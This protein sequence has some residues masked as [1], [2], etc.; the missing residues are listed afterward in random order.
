[1]AKD[2]FTVKLEDADPI[3]KDNKKGAPRANELRLEDIDPIFKDTL[4][5]PSSISSAPPTPSEL[6]NLQNLP[7]SYQMARRAIFGEQPIPPGVGEFGGGTLGAVAGGLEQG[8]NI[9][10]LRPAARAMGETITAPPPATS[11]GSGAAWLRNWAGIDRPITGGV[12]EGAQA[13]ERTKTHGEAGKQLWKRFGNQPLD[14]ARY[15]EAADEA[16]RARKLAWLKQA[17]EKTT[18]GLGYVPGLSVLAGASGG[19]DVIEAL[20]RLEK[21]DYTGAA[22]KG[23]GGLGALASLLPF[24]PT[25]LG[26]G[27]LSLLAM[28]IDAIYRDAAMPPPESLDYTAP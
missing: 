6:S 11:T 3:F 2:N 8:R 19:A 22:I 24:L 20:R 26:G 14:I 17:G 21:G 5:A 4:P 18:R 16:D 12:P 23:V 28:P 27:A 25:R 13:Y 15:T 9:L 10:N 7:E 1:M